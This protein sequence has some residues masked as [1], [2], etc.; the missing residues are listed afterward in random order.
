[1]KKNSKV[2]PINDYGSESSLSQDDDEEGKEK[3]VVQ[4]IVPTTLG[5]KMISKNEKALKSFTTLRADLKE[6]IVKNILEDVLPDI[7]AYDMDGMMAKQEAKRKGFYVT[8][9]KF[10]GCWTLTLHETVLTG[11][12]KHVEE[13]LKK[14][15][16]GKNAN[17]LIVNQY[18]EFGRTPLSYA[19]KMQRGD[20]VEALIFYKAMPDICD[21]SDG[22][23]PLLYAIQNGARDISNSLVQAGASANLCDF[24]CVTPL[25]V[26][27]ARNDIHHTI[28]LINRGADV[29]AQDLKTGWTPLHYA[30]YA[31]APDILILLLDEGADRNRR[32]LKKRKPIHIAKF[33]EHGECTHVLEDLKSR[34]ATALGEDL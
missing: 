22:R 16:T 10:F 31:N 18:D 21:E 33:Q 28:L 24:N 11:S 27:A 8:M 29:D 9:L 19:C 2:L 30:A 12:L 23:S 26:A 32:D 3:E 6:R 20:I 17:P 25:M 15:T 13:F 7:G 34:I 1:M 5:E 4:E 14:M